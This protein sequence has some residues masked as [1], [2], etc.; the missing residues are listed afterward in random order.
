MPDVILLNKQVIPDTANWW[1]VKSNIFWGKS[2]MLY[3]DGSLAFKTKK[4]GNGQQNSRTSG[5]WARRMR[6]YRGRW[7][8]K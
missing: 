6:D 5:R 1:R 3:K 4:W 8:G 7:N 2:G